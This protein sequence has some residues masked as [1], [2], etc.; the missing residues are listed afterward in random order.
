[1]GQP[2]VFLDRDG[3]INEQM[4]YI[5]HLSR[6]RLLP[7]A[8]ESI[9]R[10]NDAG[11]KVVVVT[12]QS[13]AARGYFPSTLLDE[14][15]AYLKILLDAAAAHLDGIYVCPHLPEEGCACSKPRP[16]LIEWAARVW[17]WT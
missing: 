12:N 8:I 2:G 5:N 7:Q 3:T 11:L 17:I 13:G 9:R 16:T 4:G 1:M 15:H 14:V 10:L 6:F